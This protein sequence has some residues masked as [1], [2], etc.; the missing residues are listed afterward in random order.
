MFQLNAGYFLNQLEKKN[1]IVD[2]SYR[3][4]EPL[5]LLDY[6]YSVKVGHDFFGI[7]VL[8]LSLK[9]R[10]Y[11]RLRVRLDPDRMEQ[12]VP[13]NQLMFLITSQ[14]D[15]RRIYVVEILATLILSF[16]I[17]FRLRTREHRRGCVHS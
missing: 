14:P 16:S 8:K 7:I 1:F 4:T 10:V 13:L 6:F 17:A 15:K 5:Q 9:N 11:R 12:E 3:C 2:Q